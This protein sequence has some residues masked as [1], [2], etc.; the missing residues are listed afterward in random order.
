[1]SMV[2]P[3]PDIP[4]T[5]ASCRAAIP[6]YALRT[7]VRPGLSGI[8]Q[9]YY[10]HIDALEVDAFSER[11][12]YDAYYVKNRSLA[13]YVQVLLLTVRGLLLRRGA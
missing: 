11:L 7:T 13:L 2:G 9:I 12:A 3:R 4:S 6:N 10:R 8:A 1:M 5:F